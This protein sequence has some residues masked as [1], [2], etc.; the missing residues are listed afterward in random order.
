MPSNVHV[1]VSNR[2][3]SEWIE[4]V[5]LRPELVEV[6]KNSARNITTRSIDRLRCAIIA[7]EIVRDITDSDTITVDVPSRKETR[8]IL[9]TWAPTAKVIRLSQR[10]KLSRIARSA[11]A[12]KPK[13]ASVIPA[14]R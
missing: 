14:S 6:A 3:I 13:L 11:Y 4:Y 9:L 8:K 7:S 1:K 12:D 2:T 10:L 5:T